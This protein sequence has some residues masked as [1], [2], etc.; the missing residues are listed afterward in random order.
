M[1]VCTS[2]KSRTFDLERLKLGFPPHGQGWLMLGFGLSRV[3]GSKCGG[4]EWS[5]KCCVSGEGCFGGSSLVGGCEQGASRFGGAALVCVLLTID[6]LPILASPKPQVLPSFSSPSSFLD[7]ILLAIF[8]CNHSVKLSS[9]KMSTTSVF[10]WVSPIVGTDWLSVGAGCGAAVSVQAL[11]AGVASAARSGE[12]GEE[13]RVRR[14]VA[15]AVRGGERGDGW[16]GG[17]ASE[18]WQA[19]QGFSCQRLLVRGC[20]W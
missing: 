18:E 8:S 20:G 12:C 4:W 3:Q 10:F 9:G 7:F 17:V 1:T 16:R 13:W 19:Q 2:D 14:G 5:C 11:L 6:F 15:S